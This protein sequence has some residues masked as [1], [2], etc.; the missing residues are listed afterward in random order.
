MITATSMIIFS[1]VEF[2]VIKLISMGGYNANQQQT[3]PDGSQKEGE[4]PHNFVT[5]IPVDYPRTKY[6]TG[7]YSS[8]QNFT[9]DET[10]NFSAPAHER[11]SSDM[12][13][14]ASVSSSQS[15]QHTNRTSPP[16]TSMTATAAASSACASVEKPA[17][18]RIPNG[19]CKLHRCLK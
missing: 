1:F 3:S 14:I 7:G 5:V 10:R 18:P 17:T 2:Q 19:E 11:D 4:S 13:S 6:G 16:I 12:S 9:Q 8:S 15:S